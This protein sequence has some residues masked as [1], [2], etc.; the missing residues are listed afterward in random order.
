MRQL[1]QQ[2]LEKHIGPL[3]ATAKEKLGQLPTDRPAALVETAFQVKSLQELG[4][5]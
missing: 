5:E 4:L 1:V 2:I 3:S